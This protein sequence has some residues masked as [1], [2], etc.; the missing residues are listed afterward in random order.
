MRKLS[1]DETMKIA[2]N[3]IDQVRRVDWN[4]KGRIDFV[5]AARIRDV[6]SSLKEL[7]RR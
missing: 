1:D 2:G 3:S 4:Q 6:A 5:M 7:R